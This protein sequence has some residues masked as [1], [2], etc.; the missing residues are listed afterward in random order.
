MKMTV[1][2]IENT[3]NKMTAQRI[4]TLTDCIFAV[5]MMLMVFTFSIPTEDTIFAEED[6]KIFC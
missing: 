3:T 6:I 4:Q 5:A 2:R 1:E